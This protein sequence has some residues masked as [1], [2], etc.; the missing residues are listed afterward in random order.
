MLRNLALCCV[1]VCFL[2]AGCEKTTVE[3][4]AGKKLTLVKPMDSKIVRGSTEKVSVV[5]TRQNFDAPVT[6]RFS[7]LPNGV[8]VAE[9][10]N[11]IEGNERTFVLTATDTADLVKE[12]TAMVTVTGPDGMSATEQFKITVQEKS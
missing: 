2:A 1:S 6:V 11:E 8:K 5:V 3:G 9:G 12:H 10:A 4:P 7:D